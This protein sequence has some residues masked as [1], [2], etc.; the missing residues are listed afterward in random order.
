MDGVDEIDGVAAPPMNDQGVIHLA[1]KLPQLSL[2]SRPLRAESS[3]S[4]GEVKTF[5]QATNSQETPKKQPRS[6]QDVLPAVNAAGKAQRKLVRSRD[7]S[8]ATSSP[9]KP[10]KRVANGD[11]TAGKRVGVAKKSVLAKR[12]TS[13]GF[14]AKPSND[15]VVCDVLTVGG[16]ALNVN[17]TG[18]QTTLPSVKKV[19]KKRKGLKAQVSTDGAWKGKKKTVKRHLS[20]KQTHE[21]KTTINA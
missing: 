1:S 16:A 4:R 9:E 19:T 17:A 2:Q 12:S 3:P 13:R 8:P 15:E 18:E 11:I 20:G 10:T 5:G 21:A 14:S 7:A 6:A